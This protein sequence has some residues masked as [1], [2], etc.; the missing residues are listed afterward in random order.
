MVGNGLKIHPIH[1]NPQQ[2][3]RG[4]FVTDTAR[5][6]DATSQYEC[7]IFYLDR[8]MWYVSQKARFLDKTFSL[9]IHKATQTAQA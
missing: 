7:L 9:L 3:S 1:P 6:P 2:I 4:S 8:D 5:P